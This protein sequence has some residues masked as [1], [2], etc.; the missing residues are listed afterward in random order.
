MRHRY[1]LTIVVFAL[2]STVAVSQRHG[3]ADS[4]Q[5]YSR[6]ISNFSSTPAKGRQSFPRPNWMVKY[7]SGSLGLKTGQWLK[8]AFV[9]RAALPNSANLISRVSADQIVAIEFS[10]KTEKDSDLLQGPRSGCSEA[11]SLMPDTSKSPPDMVIATTISPGGVSRLAERLRPKHAVR[12]V[13]NEADEQRSMAL[14]VNDCEYQSFIAN[15]RWAIGP[16]WR[17]VGRELTT[18]ANPELRIQR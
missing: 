18:Q 15:I 7:D 3:G 2:L 9:P 12:F 16:R 17:E 1:R 10:A 8:I 14:K 5:N 6:G 4:V 13:W 11:R